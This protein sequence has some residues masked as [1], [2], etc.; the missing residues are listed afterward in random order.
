[1]ILPLFISQL[2]QSLASISVLHLGCTCETANFISMLIH[3]IFLA[4]L[5]SLFSKMP[6]LRD[7]FFFRSLL[8]GGIFLII[9]EFFDFWHIVYVTVQGSLVFSYGVD[10]WVEALQLIGFSIILIALI[11]TFR[12]VSI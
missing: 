10:L 7:D 6:W 5:I 2:Q 12:E 9:S 4:L 3:L 8:S 1:M 11:K